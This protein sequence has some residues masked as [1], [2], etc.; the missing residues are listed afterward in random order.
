MSYTPLT[1]D[2]YDDGRSTWASKARRAIRGMLPEL[3]GTPA[4]KCVL[5]RKSFPWGVKKRWPY[6]VWCRES[7]ILSGLA[8]QEAK[9]KQDR[10]AELFRSVQ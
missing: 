4:E 3:S 1:D 2:G 7:R 6:R 5:I 8:L 10:E 9:D